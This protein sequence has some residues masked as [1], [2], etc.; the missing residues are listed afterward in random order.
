MAAGWGGR[1]VAR[2]LPPICGRDCG[3]TPGCHR[4]SG[5]SAPLASHSHVPRQRPPTTPPPATQTTGG[6]WEW[7]GCGGG[8]GSPGENL[9]C[10]GNHIMGPEEAAALKL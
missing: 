2:A 5:A 7:G 4:D 6:A 8:Q 3:Q 1:W 10:P 9:S